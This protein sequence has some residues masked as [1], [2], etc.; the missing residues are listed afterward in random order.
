MCPQFEAASGNCPYSVK[1]STADG[2][3][4][5]RKSRSIRWSQNHVSHLTGWRPQVAPG[6]QTSG[7]RGATGRCTLERNTRT[8]QTKHSN[9]IYISTTAHNTQVRHTA[10]EKLLHFVRRELHCTASINGSCV[11]PGDDQ[12]DLIDTG[13]R[14]TQLGAVCGGLRFQQRKPPQTASP[15]C[16]SL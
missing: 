1:K 4:G 9:E 2:R 11:V 6:E 13:N 15:P 12:F 5:L 8:N 16:L 14:N 10:L 7:L 3:R